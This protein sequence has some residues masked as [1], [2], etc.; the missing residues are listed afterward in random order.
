MRLTVITVSTANQDPKET[1]RP[2]RLPEAQ[3]F[4]SYLLTC[5]I[6]KSGTSGGHP[7]IGKTLDA[8]SSHVLVQAYGAW[9]SA[10]HTAR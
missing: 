8:T 6:V 10:L 5:A 3:A 2:T 7:I 1:S 9:R 4:R